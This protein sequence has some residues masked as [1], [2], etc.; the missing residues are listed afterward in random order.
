M[1]EVGQHVAFVQTGHGE[2]GNDHLQ[3]R[4]EGRENAK[5][6]GIEAES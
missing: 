2:L 4:R 3:E 1:R 6:F 5:L